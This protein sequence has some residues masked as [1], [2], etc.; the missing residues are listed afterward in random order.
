MPPEPLSLPWF[1]D[2]GTGQLVRKRKSV[3]RYGPGAGSARVRVL[4]PNEQIL[5]LDALTAALDGS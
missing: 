3:V 4:G 2:L 5:Q 1:L